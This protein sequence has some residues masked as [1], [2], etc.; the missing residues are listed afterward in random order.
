[1]D[2]TAAHGGKA[3]GLAVV[4]GHLAQALR[5]AETDRYGQIEFPADGLLYFP[6]DVRIGHAVETAQPGDVG[7]AF[8]DGIF[9]DDRGVAPHDLEHAFGIDAVAFVIARQ[10]HQIGAFPARF[11]QAN[12]A[13]DAQRLGFVAGAGDDAALLAAH[14][15]TS[16]Q[17]GMHGLLHRGEEGV[18]I[19]VQNGLRKGGRHDRLF[20]GSHYARRYF[21][22]PQITQITVDGFCFLPADHADCRR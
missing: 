18:A 22:C 21:F 1:V 8:I 20:P 14:D 12:A 19:D 10:Y 17:L 5:K 7:K 13:F 15:G 9:F 6:G 2:V 11:P 16:L 4:G 3:A